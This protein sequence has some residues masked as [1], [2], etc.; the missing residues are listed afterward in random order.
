VSTKVLSG[1]PSKPGFYTII[2]SVP[3]N[4][5][6]PAHSHRDDRMASVVSGTWQFG[7]G[8]RFDANALKRLP[9]G[10]VYSE[11]SLGNHV[12]AHG[13]RTRTRADH[14]NRTD[15]HA[16]RQS[17]GCAEDTRS[18]ARGFSCM[19]R[20]GTSSV[21]GLRSTHVSNASSAGH[22]ACPQSVRLYS[23]FGGT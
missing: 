5:T 14:G 4:T 1:D 9:P 21:E 22:N 13:C 8:D 15:R 2:L 18:V 16:L 19:A 17:A 10:S 6:I 12:C 11:P 3:A 20:T 23:T 7:Y